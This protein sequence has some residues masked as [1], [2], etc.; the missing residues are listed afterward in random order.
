MH[1]IEFFTFEKWLYGEL[2]YKHA[3]YYKTGFVFLKTYLHTR[4]FTREN[5]QDWII[6]LQEQELSPSTI[7]NYQKTAKLIDR[8]R[9]EVQGHKRELEGFKQLKTQ[10]PDVEVL[11]GEEMKQLLEVAYDIKYR[12]ALT[13]ETWL[14]TGLRMNE[15]RSIQWHN[16][17]KEYIFIYNSKNGKSR[18][19]EIL[20]DLYEKIQKLKRSKYVFGFCN[21]KLGEDQIRSFL[22]DCLNKAGIDKKI[23]PHKCRHTYATHMDENGVSHFVIRDLLGQTDIRSTEVYIHTNT[24]RRLKAQKSH[25]LNNSPIDHKEIK[26]DIIKRILLIEDVQK[27]RAI[28]YIL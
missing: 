3:P 20:P 18:R 5:V 9:H 17:H 14:R 15:L 23:T 6:S 13:I 24:K 19:A 26:E 10:R 28:E 25:V 22:K 12:Y 4:Y 8:Y 11:T 2:K 27:L 16:I 7:N 1:N 21:Q